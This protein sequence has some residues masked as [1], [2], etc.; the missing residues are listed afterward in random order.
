MFSSVSSD[1]QISGASLLYST[2]WVGK[3]M[4]ADRFEAHDPHKIIE[5]L[6]KSWEKCSK[7]QFDH[8]FDLFVVITQPP[9]EEWD[10]PPTFSKPP[11]GS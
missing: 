1:G 4:T 10:L 2:G 11:G 5:G 3:K 7:F 6:N 9:L 8:I